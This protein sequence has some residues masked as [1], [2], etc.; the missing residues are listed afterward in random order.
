MTHQDECPAIDD[1]TAMLIEHG[2]AAMATA[3]ATAEMY[4]QGVST[5]KTVRPEVPWQRC[6]FHAIQNARA[7]VPK[8][9]MRTEVARN[10]RRIFDADETAL[11]ITTAQQNVPP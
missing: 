8:V 9:A 11:R 5:R 4:V 2:P 6:Q 7:H 1:L 10:L 3:L